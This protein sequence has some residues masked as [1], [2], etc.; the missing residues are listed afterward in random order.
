[1]LGH[2]SEKATWDIKISEMKHQI[3]E[4]KSKNDRLQANLEQKEQ[5]IGSLK[6]E[7]KNARRNYMTAAK[8]TDNALSA[9]LGAGLMNKLNLPGAKVG[10]GYQ[11][12]MYGAQ[13][14]SN[15]T[16]MDGAESARSFS[17]RFGATN[18]VSASMDL[19]GK[20]GQAFQQKHNLGLASAANDNTDTSSQRSFNFM[21]PN[22]RNPQSRK[23]ELEEM[24]APN[25]GDNDIPDQ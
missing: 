10:G 21:T 25:T 15:V 8:N 17:T 9:N 11:P 7:A 19:S 5:M 6:S 2:E 1:M 13:K 23:S 22:N 3:D 12:K 18:Q 4:L 16:E 24:D 14:P 20:F